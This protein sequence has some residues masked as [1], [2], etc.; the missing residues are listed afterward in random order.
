MV[1][2]A[3]LSYRYN[4]NRFLSEFVTSRLGELRGGLYHP[5]REAY[6]FVAW[7]FRLKAEYLQLAQHLMFNSTLNHH[8]EIVA[9]GTKKVLQ[10]R[11][12]LPSDLW[13]RKFAFSHHTA[14]D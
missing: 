6:L 14:S 9:P 13:V 8:G 3:M 12:D 5:G 11:A 1:H 4:L 10:G 7:Q 2:L